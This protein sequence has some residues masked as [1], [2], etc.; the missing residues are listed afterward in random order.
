LLDTF[1][2]TKLQTQDF[3]VEVNAHHHLGEIKSI[4]P[5]VNMLQFS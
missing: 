2:T 1:S 3:K 4:K 5:Q